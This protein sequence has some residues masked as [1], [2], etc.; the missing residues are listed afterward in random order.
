MNRAGAQMAVTERE[1]IWTAERHIPFQKQDILTCCTLHLAPLPVSATTSLNARNT[2]RALD[3][4][5]LKEIPIFKRRRFHS[6]P[7]KLE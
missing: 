6:I 2:V 5:L 1:Q 7:L 3:C 4:Q